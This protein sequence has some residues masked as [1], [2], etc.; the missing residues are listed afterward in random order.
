[1]GDH[2]EPPFAPGSIRVPFGR[3]QREHVLVR[4]EVLALP[5]QLAGGRVDDVEPPG[6]AGMEHDLLPVSIVT[7][8]GEVASRSQTSCGM[9][10]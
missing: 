2:S 8:D 7:T 6:L 5:H 3:R 4:D 1:M 9:V 10:W